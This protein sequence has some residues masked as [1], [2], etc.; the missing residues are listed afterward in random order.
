MCC[1]KITDTGTGT[2]MGYC[3]ISHEV[4]IAAVRLYEC[5]LLDLED[6]L[7][8]CG[9]ACCIWFWVLKLWH[10]TGDVVLPESQSNWGQERILDQEDLT[11]L[12]KLIHDNPDYFLDELPHLLKTNRFISVHYTTIFRE[13][14]RLNVSLK[15]LTRIALERDEDCRADFVA[16]MAQYSPEELGFLDKMSKDGQSIESRYGRACKNKC[17]QKNQVF[18]CG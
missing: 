15:K 8:C 10:E 7:D 13:L 18:V 14:E 3:F 4:K 5:G 1:L 17:T 6:I 9:F 16:C 2:S 12:L 11:Y